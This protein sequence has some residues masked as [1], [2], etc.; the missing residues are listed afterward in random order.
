MTG[1]TKLV[2]AFQSGSGRDHTLDGLAAALDEALR[3]ARSAWTSIEAST[4]EFARAI[5]SAVAEQDDPLAGIAALR[6]GDLWLATAAA[7]GN[8]L[9]VEAI[10]AILTSLRPTLARM[11]A[12]RSTID[13]LLQRVSVHLLAGSQ[14]QPSRIRSY[15]GRGEL[16]SW[17]KVVVVRDAVRAL[18]AERGQDTPADELEALMDPGGDPELEAMRSTYR[19]AFRA[20]FSHALSELSPRDRNVLRYHLAEGLTIDDLAAL[21]QVHRA[22]TARWLARIREGLFVSTRTRLMQALD[23]GRDDVDSVIRM[24]QSCLDTSIVRHLEPPSAL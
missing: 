1:G 16:R 20:A 19:E 13:E 10:E 18:R 4:D 14:D 6:H 23:L 22:T 15:R 12:A 9:A 5:G 8:K 21:Y 7:Q 3:S 2:A 17:I 11:G 24:I